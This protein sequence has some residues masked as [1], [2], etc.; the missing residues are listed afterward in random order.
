M[1]QITDTQTDLKNR[2][3]IQAYEA[4]KLLGGMSEPTF[5][6]HIKDKKIRSHRIGKKRLFF[7]DELLEDLKKL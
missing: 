2:Y 3:P 7:A 4:K 6:K 1:A 5:A